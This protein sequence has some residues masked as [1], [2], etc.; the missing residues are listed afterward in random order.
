MYRALLDRGILQNMRARGI[1][2]V[3]IY[4]VDNVLVRLAD[5]AFIGFCISRAA[6]CA[7]KV[8]EKTDPAEPIGVVGVV[9]GKFRVVEYSEISPSTAALVLPMPPSRIACCQDEKDCDSKLANSRLLYC[10]GNICNHFMTLTFLERVCNPELESQLPYHVARKKVPHIDLETGTTITPTQ[11]NALKLE[12]FIFDVFQ[13]SQRF[14]IWEV[15]RATEFSPLK[16]RSGAQNDCP[17]TCRQS[18]LNLHASWARAAGAV[19]ASEDNINRDVIE[20][21]PL[22]SLN[23][24]NLECLK[25]KTITGVNI[26][27]LRRS[28]DGEDVPTLIQVKANN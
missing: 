11:P 16:N 15:D 4:G 14:A 26:L 9:D 17:E 25:G 28:E 23:G 19:F 5:P 10:H 12:K 27:E 18:I 6:D 7:V 20:I 24:E 8:V 1:D 2:Y 21:S 3:H 22:V 13:F